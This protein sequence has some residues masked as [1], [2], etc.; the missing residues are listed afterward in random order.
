M[1]CA[2]RSIIY[3]WG[4]YYPHDFWPRMAQNQEVKKSEEKFRNWVFTLNNPN[5]DDF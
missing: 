3:K 1:F 4:Q 2:K 5:E